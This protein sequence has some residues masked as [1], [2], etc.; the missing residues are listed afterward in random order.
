MYIIKVDK[1]YDDN[2]VAESYY[3]S[4]GPEVRAH[5]G[6]YRRTVDAR[7]AKLFENFM[8]DD[9]YRRENMTCKVN[10]TYIKLGMD[11]IVNEMET[12]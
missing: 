8:V 6:T 10:L 4:D 2:M 9:F 3:L 7:K 12:I 5:S 1:L 11:N